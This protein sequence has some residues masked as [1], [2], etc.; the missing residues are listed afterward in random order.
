MGDE[1]VGFLQFG[2]VCRPVCVF[3]VGGEDEGEEWVLSVFDEEE[4][5]G[6][7]GGEEGEGEGGEGGEGWGGGGGRAGLKG[8]GEE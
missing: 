5:G 1:S 6:G 8:K 4:E 3:E 2:V 7:G